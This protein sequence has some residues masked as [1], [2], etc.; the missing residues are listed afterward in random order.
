[1]KNFTQSINFPGSLPLTRNL[2][3]AAWLTNMTQA[4]YG[5]ISDVRQIS[6]RKSDLVKVTIVPTV[7]GWF[8]RLEI[9]GEN[10]F[11]QIYLKK[12]RKRKYNRFHLVSV[13]QP[14]HGCIL[15]GEST[16]SSTHEDP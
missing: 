8:I 6:D 2:L 11:Y 15:A 5:F 7:S 1:M 16:V 14:V 12:Y 9:T 4:R 13:K 3:A 10:P